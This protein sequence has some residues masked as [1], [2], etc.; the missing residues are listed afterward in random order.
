M[1]DPAINL[2]A[3]ELKAIEEHKYFL[4]QSRGQEVTIEEAIADFIKH[5]E[6]D[7]RREKL[8]RDNH[9]QRQEIEKHQYLRSQAEGRDIG[10]SSAAVEWCQK[11]APIWRTERESLEK[12]GF[13][14]VRVTVQDEAGLHLRP[15]STVA[16][17]AERFD[18]DMYVHRA[19][20]NHYNFLLDGRPYRN[21][22]SVIGMLALGASQG[23]ELEF[24]ATG[25]EAE[26]ALA[27]LAELLSQP[28][29]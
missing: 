24:I 22:R 11:Y 15:V 19:G 18:C 4:S 7:W 27:A 1:A 10:R 12:N 2:T 23:D 16:E 21:V 17:L 20:M 6:D 3:A 13:R 26:E 14:S 8:R 25:A 9:E 28:R 5:Y 29:T